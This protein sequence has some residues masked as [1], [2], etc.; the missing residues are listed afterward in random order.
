M[1]ID[2]IKQGPARAPARAM[3]RATGLDGAAIARPLV[4][5]VHTWTDVSPCNFT[6]RDLA[7]HV[8]AGVIRGGGTSVEFNTIAVT[9]GIA[10][11]SDGMRA[12][13]AS[14]E[15]IA[16]SI[17]LAVSRSEEHTSELQSLMR[18]S[19]A[20]FCLKKKKTQSQ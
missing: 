15:T 8:R 17:E 12:S 2:A 11:G 10:M 4:A 1:R 7:R 20:V 6:L 14:R 13:L 16:D 5:V 19:Y 9:D 3:L 18:I